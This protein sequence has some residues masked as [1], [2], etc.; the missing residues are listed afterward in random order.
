[1]RFGARAGA[2]EDYVPPAL[3]RV[4]RH[5]QL[6]QRDLFVNVEV[7]G[8]LQDTQAWF[9]LELDPSGPD[10]P[11]FSNVFV[12][13]VL[14]VENVVRA[15]ADPIVDDGLR[16]RHPVH[17]PAELVGPRFRG[18][19]ERFELLEVER[20]CELEGEQEITL[21]PS[22]LG[23]PERT[24][25][26]GWHVVGGREQRHLAL[27]VPGTPEAPRRVRVDGQWTQPGFDPRNLGRAR[28]RPWRLALPNV[29]WK[30]RP[31]S[32]SSLPSPLTNAP[33]KLL[34][35]LALTNREKLSLEDLKRLLNLLSAGAD[36]PWRS[37][38][39]CV[40]S[41][42]WKERPADPTRGGTYLEA[43]LRCRSLGD[44]GQPLLEDLIA[45][46]EVVLNAWCQDP[47][48]VRQAPVVAS[49]PLR[50]AGVGT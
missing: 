22:A 44:E 50:L 20:V 13:N 39:E 8:D 35:L 31:E 43:T 48:S 25:R 6:P 30:L 21:F 16:S 42:S 24:Y 14:P 4:R 45:Q 41:L 3:E 1:M 34:E 23:D 37:V 11:W 38:V 17:P 19:A 47:V 49:I 12:P 29:A 7:P 28:V 46:V 27:G 33:D 32:A 40:E 2:P 18:P 9:V 15:P 5:F 10:L 26:L 36:V